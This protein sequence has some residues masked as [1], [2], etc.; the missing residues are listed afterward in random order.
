VLSEFMP[1][2]RSYRAGNAIHLG[3]KNQSVNA[4]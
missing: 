1:K 2:S 4:V 3:Y